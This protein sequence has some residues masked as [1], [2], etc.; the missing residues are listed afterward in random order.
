MADGLSPW[1]G[2]FRKGNVLSGS[3]GFVESV[4][5]WLPFG[6]K[7]RGGPGLE[8]TPASALGFNDRQVILTAF[9]FVG[10]TGFKEVAMEDGLRFCKAAREFRQ[11]RIAAPEFAVVGGEEQPR[12]RGIAET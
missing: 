11:R 2:A 12:V 4:S 6:I 9:D 8:V 10:G 7:A 1:S 5:E 3:E